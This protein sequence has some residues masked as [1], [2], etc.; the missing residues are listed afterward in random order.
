MSN[1]RMK[2][3]L[4]PGDFYRGRG[5][6]RGGI[7]FG[8]RRVAKKLEPGLQSQVLRSLDMGSKNLKTLKRLDPANEPE[9]RAEFDEIQNLSKIYAQPQFV[10]SSILGSLKIYFGLGLLAAALAAVGVATLLGPTDQPFLR[11]RHQGAPGS[12]GKGSL[13]RAD[14]LL[15]GNGQGART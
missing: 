10:K 2:L 12:P 6:D 4:F 11:G 7:L 9:Y 1:S 15:A 5:A 13:S 8:G 3:L 14:V